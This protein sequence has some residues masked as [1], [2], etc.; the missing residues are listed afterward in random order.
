MRRNQEPP[1][2]SAAAQ[3]PKPSSGEPQAAGDALAAVNAALR[4]RA[5]EA[6]RA[7]D[8]LKQ[9]IAATDVATI[10]VD[11]A[12]T[13]RRYTPQAES[14]FSL[15]PVD[16]GRSLMDVS[17]CLDYPTLAE[18]TTT[19]VA[20]LQAVEREVRSVDGRRF[21]V[22]IRPYQAAS[23]DIDGAVL[24]FVDVTSLRMAE[25]RAT[26]NADDLHDILQRSKDFAV[27][28]A[29]PGGLISGWN[30]GAERIFGY[31]AA[32][33]IGQP[34]HVIF[35][36]E[37]IAQRRPEKEMHKARTTGRAEDDRWHLR[38]DGARIFCSGVMTKLD[39]GDRPGFVKIVRDMTQQQ[40]MLR[41]GERKLMHARARRADAE[42]ANALKD[43]FL[44]VM[45]HEL[46][47]PLNLIHVNAELIGRAPDLGID[48]SPMAAKALR[49]ISR[50][51]RTQSKIID[52]LLDL[53]RM[54]TGKLALDRTAVDLVALAEMAAEVAA[55]DT[56]AAGIR[57]GFQSAGPHLFVD[58]DA[59]RLNQVLWNL[60][61]NALKFTPAGGSVDVVVSAEGGFGRLDVK[62][63]GIGIEPANLPRIFEMFG[64]ARARAT[65]AQGGL[66]IGL[67]LVK[68]L[69]EHHGGRVEAVS[70][71]SGMGAC[72]SVWIPLFEER[73]AIEAPRMDREAAQCCGGLRILVV[74]DDAVTVDSLRALLELEGATV[75]TATS[76]TAALAEIDDARPDIV[77][78]DLGMPGRDGYALLRDIR[79]RENLRTLP[80][81]ALTGFGGQHDVRRAMKAGFTHHIGKPVDFAHLLRV[82]AEHVPGSGDARAAP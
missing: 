56:A 8:E 39:V 37:D 29:E 27:I 52:D 4:R 47:H 30:E 31:V 13:I 65:S 18:D 41:V 10:F 45:S 51:V 2:P 59:A 20:T 42:A 15:V 25:E 78:T 50:A 6:E 12:I 82:I 16:I 60:L 32:E 79:A 81:I 11:A 76:A 67:A 9:L 64:Q 35:V 3:D 58:A 21:V 68:Q 57:I 33:A 26:R 55:A 66:G 53:S 72:F 71:G 43:E 69:A 14:L 1:E 23:R 44:A 48:R 63:S 36:P 74:D 5:E 38:K 49:T 24:N 46:K 19:T 62:D 80:V 17:H 54:R 75:A 28:V 73:L 34:I 61:G 70:D 40:E 22:R 7:K 77:V